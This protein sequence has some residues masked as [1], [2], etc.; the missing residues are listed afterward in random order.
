[1]CFCCMVVLFQTATFNAANLQTAQT[2]NLVDQVRGT[3]ECEKEG[4]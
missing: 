3:C 1:M 2:G 4:V